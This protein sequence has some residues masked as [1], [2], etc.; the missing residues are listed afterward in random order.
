M[1]LRW[2][3]DRSAPL[4][5]GDRKLRDEV[6]YFGLALAAANAAMLY[7]VGGWCGRAGGNGG[8]GD[9]ASG[10]RSP[11]EAGAGGTGSKGG[12]RGKGKAGVT[13]AVD[14]FDMARG[15]WEPGKTMLAKR[16]YHGA[17]VLDGKVFV[18]GGSDSDRGKST[19]DVA[20]YNPADRSWSTAAP[21]SGPRQGVATV[22]LGR[23]L[24]AIG[25]FGSS[26]KCKSRVERFDPRANAWQ[27]V[28]PLPAPRSGA[29]AV[30]LHGYIYVVGGWDGKKCVDT[31]L[32]YDSREDKWA[33]MAPLPTPC[34]GLACA[35]AQ[36]ALFAVGGGVVD[37][38]PRY[39]ADGK[40]MPTGHVTAVRS[41]YT[42]APNADAWR[43][44][45]PMQTPRMCAG[46]A[47]FQGK[48]YV[49]GGQQS[50]KTPLDSMEIFGLATGAWCNGP[51]LPS[52][53]TAH[54]ASVAAPYAWA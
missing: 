4:P 47:T 23:Y 40:K 15:V 3:G 26:N 24:Y 2:L 43:A 28:R 31:T 20:Q 48:V 33:K 45:Q 6:E 37:A 11:P 34:Y 51:P 44:I 53:R 18:V 12:V 29:A 21:L 32:R 46:C 52:P 16:S 22:T 41:A 1:L 27:T 7:V 5:F 35:A 17:A 14:C 13:A 10:A 39:D 19:A 54:T 50:D 38:T 25:G 49:L 30:V 36:G 9:D 42:Y 8:G